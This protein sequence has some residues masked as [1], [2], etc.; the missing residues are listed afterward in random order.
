MSST[1][2]LVGAEPEEL[3][4]HSDLL[5]DLRLSPSDTFTF[6]QGI[7]GFPACRKFAI[8]RGGQDRLYWMQSMEHSTL[9]F[10]LVDPFAVFENYAVD[11]PP[12]HL[13]Q[14]GAV[15]TAANIALLAFVTLPGQTGEL[16]TVNLQ[17]PVAINFRTRL[18][19]Q[20]VLADTEY[21]VRC[22]VDLKTVIAP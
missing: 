20:I 19:K 14:L 7:L 9:V 16:P 3:I 17:G 13:A 12:S 10:L 18:A 1:L 5:G 8:V 6:P 11:M 22:P 2:T 4:V 15:D 21:G